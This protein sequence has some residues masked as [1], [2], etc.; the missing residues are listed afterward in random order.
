MSKLNSMDHPPLPLIFVSGGRPA[1]SACKVSVMSHHRQL[2]SDRWTGAQNCPTDRNFWH[3]H[4]NGLPSSMLT[5]CF[6]LV[7]PTLILIELWN[8]GKINQFDFTRL[9]NISKPII[10][11]NFIAQSEL[12]CF[13]ELGVS[14]PPDDRASSMRCRPSQ[15][16]SHRHQTC[17]RT[18]LFP[19]TLPQGWV[20][21]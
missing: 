4:Q 14:D 6:N 17:T 19:P 9:V 20:T 13:S 12:D 5:I 8:S 7:L 16:G 2:V 18:V 21:C 11:C 1:R 10:L 15:A 3:E